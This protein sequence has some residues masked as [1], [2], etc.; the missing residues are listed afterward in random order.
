MGISVVLKQKQLDYKSIVSRVIHWKYFNEVG[1][2]KQKKTLIKT[3]W[4]RD[5]RITISCENKTFEWS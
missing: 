1:T 3:Y 4:N 2:L 5:F